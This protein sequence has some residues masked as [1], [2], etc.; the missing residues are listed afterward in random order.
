MVLDYEELVNVVEYLA[1]KVGFKLDE[2][3]KLESLC[4]KIEHQNLAVSLNSDKIDVMQPGIKTAFFF[5][6]VGLVFKKPYLNN[7]F[8]EDLISDIKVCKNKVIITDLNNQK[9]ELNKSDVNV[10][11]INEIPLDLYMNLIN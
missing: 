9:I 8:D 4:K 3:I 2:D 10:K 5:K 11:I 1:K 7:K 6:N